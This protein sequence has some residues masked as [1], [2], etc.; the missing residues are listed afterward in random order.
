MVGNGSFWSRSLALAA[1]VENGS[2]WSHS[3]RSPLLWGTR[4]LLVALV[5][6]RR[7][8]EYRI[9]TMRPMVLLT[10]TGPG[11]VETLLEPGREGRLGAARLD[12]PVTGATGAA[13]AWVVVEDGRGTLRAGEHRVTVDGRADVFADA[14]WSAF[15]GPDSEFALDGDLR[16]TVVWRA[17]EHAAAT[18]L[19]DP[20]TVATEERGEDTTARRVRT[21]IPQGELIVGETLNPAGGWSSYPPHRHAHEELYLYRFSAPNGFG[22][23]VSYDDTHDEARVVREGSIERITEGYHPVVAAPA[24]EM[25]YLWALAGDADTVDTEIDP[26]HRPHP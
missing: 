5:G 12:G 18:T 15:V 22:V 2:F 26:D 10:F 8:N 23:H 9:G 24:T 20:A 4:V 17:S 19:I 1:V 13:V 21:Y 14:G 11:R 25:Y 7:S 6:A 16:A 3:L